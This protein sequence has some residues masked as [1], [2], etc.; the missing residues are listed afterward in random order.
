[1]VSKTYYRGRVVMRVTLST[2]LL[3]IL[4][5]II[6]Q[7]V[8]SSRG[9]FQISV[10]SGPFA[11]ADWMVQ[12]Y[13]EIDYDYNSGFRDA[14]ATG[15]G[16]G[17][18]IAICGRYSKSDWGVILD[19]GV[20]L[21]TNRKFTI[22][23]SL[24]SRKFENKLTVVPVTISIIYKIKT[25]ESR[26]TP[27]LGLGPGI[28]FSTWETKDFYI[29]NIFIREWYKGKNTSVGAHFLVGMDYRFYRRFELKMQYRYSFILSKWVLDDQDSQDTL[30]IFD[31]NLG[32]TSL[33][34]GIGYNF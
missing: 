23:T 20:R 11:P 8:Y 2:T 1:M 18:D 22:N 17:A 28:Y 25:G 3:F 16:A 6:P 29:S 9:E 10:Q 7:S 4:I 27:Y 14:Y 5:S 31:L 33:R 26:F 13:E 32:G 24:G 21:H 34:F 30:D 19:T 12:G 15:F